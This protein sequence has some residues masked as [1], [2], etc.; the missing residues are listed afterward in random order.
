MTT[1][2]Y[3]PAAQST[4]KLAAVAENLPA[5]QSTHVADT[6][7]PVAVEYFPA[8]QSAQAFHAAPG[9]EVSTPARMDSQL[10]HARTLIL[11]YLAVTGWLKLL[12]VFAVLECDVGR[13]NRVVPSTAVADTKFEVVSEYC[14]SISNTHC[15]PSKRHCVTTP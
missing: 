4:Q 1:A 10:Y 13:K 12:M 14:T 7:A 3:L 2:V 15:S 8:P 9:S 11:M 5:A 6:V